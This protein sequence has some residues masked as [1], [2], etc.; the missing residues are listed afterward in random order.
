M[1]PVNSLIL[2]LC[3]VPL[4]LHPLP[5][6][7]SFYL[8]EGTFLYD[9]HHNI[10]KPNDAWTV[11]ERQST[12]DSEGVV[13][14]EDIGWPLCTGLAIT[15]ASRHVLIHVS[16]G[17]RDRDTLYYCYMNCDIIY[18]GCKKQSDWVRICLPTF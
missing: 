16:K 14:C 12:E 18:Q 11:D 17:N 4:L 8:P 7:L 10:L 13:E 1:G 5:P 15:A 6:P 9:Y 2:L 3:F